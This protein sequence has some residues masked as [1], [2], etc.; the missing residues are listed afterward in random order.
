M[1]SYSTIPTDVESDKMDKNDDDADRVF[2][3]KFFTAN[4]C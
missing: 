1:A 4:S 3:D 2:W